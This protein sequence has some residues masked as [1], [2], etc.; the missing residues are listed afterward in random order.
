M[1]GL[2]GKRRR[3]SG[4]PSTRFPA[5]ARLGSPEVRS[6]D[7]FRCVRRSQTSC[8]G[9]WRRRFRMYSVH[10]GTSTG[11]AASSIGM[12]CSAN[13][14][15]I[16]VMVTPCL[17]AAARSPSFRRTGISIQRMCVSSPRRFF[18]R[19]ARISLTIRSANSLGVRSASKG[20]S[21]FDATL[22]LVTQCPLRF[23]AIRIRFV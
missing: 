15:R 16:S 5:L 6:W 7:S 18:F 13:Q 19:R 8:R 23:A 17:S 12:I 1:Q 20:L 14:L 4:S 21:D 11:S 10:P 2:P 9:R 22:K 3:L